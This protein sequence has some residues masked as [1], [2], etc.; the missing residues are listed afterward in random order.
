MLRKKKHC[1]S[2]IHSALGLNQSNHVNALKHLQGCILFT[3]TSRFYNKKIMKKIYKPEIT[4]VTLF[5]S[6]MLISLKVINED[7]KI[8]KIWHLMEKYS[9]LRKKSPI[10]FFLHLMPSELYPCKTKVTP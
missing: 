9:L 1:S 2:T 4:K 6:F 8:T 5:L 10:N 3:E 7:T